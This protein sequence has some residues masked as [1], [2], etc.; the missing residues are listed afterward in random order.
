MSDV[1]TQ[2]RAA[3]ARAATPTADAPRPS[4]NSGKTETPHRGL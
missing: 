4:L 3:G 1:A 2:R